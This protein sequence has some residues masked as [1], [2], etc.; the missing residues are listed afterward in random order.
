MSSKLNRPKLE[1]ALKR[2]AQV[3]TTGPRSARAGRFVSTG[4]STRL[5]N[6]VVIDNVS[7]TAIDRI[8]YD[9]R[10]AQLSITF[11]SGRTYVYEGVARDTYRD[12]LS[13]ESQGAYFNLNI[14]DAY[15]FREVR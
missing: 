1:A 13:A 5:G 8:D 10:R 9:E 12:L 7:S 6:S 11:K 3:A 15:E 2:A 14:R 4:P